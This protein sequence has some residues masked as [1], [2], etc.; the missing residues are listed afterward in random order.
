MFRVMRYCL[1]CQKLSTA[2]AISKSEVQGWKI[3]FVNQTTERTPSFGIIMNGIVNRTAKIRITRTCYSYI[4]LIQDKVPL[5]MFQTNWDQSSVCSTVK[6]IGQ[7]CFFLRNM[8][9]K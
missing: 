4:F 8:L 7:N 9:C 3:L 2:K 5:V 6:P 1:V